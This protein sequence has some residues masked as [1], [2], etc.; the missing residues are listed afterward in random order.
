MAL[1]RT[2]AERK[3]LLLEVAVAEGDQN[4]S[5]L[6]LR[7]FDYSSMG[8]EDIGE[9]F[10]REELLPILKGIIEIPF[11][12]PYEKMAFGNL[13]HKIIRLE[14]NGT[15][16]SIKGI[17]GGK[18]DLKDNRI[19]L[20]GASRDFG[21]VPHEYQERLKGLFELLCQKPAYQGFQAHFEEI[22]PQS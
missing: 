2:G 7:G 6:Y 5:R 15:M 22:N 3:Y 17:G 18:F 20:R 1:K 12:W 4:F 13:P 10:L 19:N 14:Q 9:N 11:S 8:H 21:P 16:F